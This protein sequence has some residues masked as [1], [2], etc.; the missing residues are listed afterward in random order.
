LRDS[1]ELIDNSFY[2]VGRDDR[3]NPD[4]LP[5]EALV[6]DLD[7]SKPVILIDHQPVELNEAEESG[8]TLELAG[9]THAGQFFPATI[10]VPCVFENSHGYSRRGNTHF[11]VSSGL[12]V[13]GRQ[14]RLGSNSEIIN[15]RLRY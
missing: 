14:S 6:R 5:V 4:R 2:V 9:H 13:W 8:V 12:G 10:I 11:V 7:R 3:T 1:S 15:I